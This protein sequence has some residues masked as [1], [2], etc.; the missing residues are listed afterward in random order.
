MKTAFKLKVILYQSILKEMIF[1]ILIPIFPNKLI[2]MRGIK[3]AYIG[4]MTVLLGDEFSH[5][6]LDPNCVSL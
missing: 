2:R 6:A 3:V 5:V 1:Y 4:D